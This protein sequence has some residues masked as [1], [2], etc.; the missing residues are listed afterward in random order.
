MTRKSSRR[1]FLK[2]SALAASA[3]FGV[4]TILSARAPNEKLGIA[5]IGCGG[6]GGGNPGTAASD[7]TTASTTDDQRCL[8]GACASETL[9]VRRC[10]GP[11]IPHDAPHF[12]CQVKRDANAR[13]V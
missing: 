3:A 6:Q 4:P 1:S 13:P 5:V 2:Q 10:P 9:G 7:A 11:S 12:G 8:M